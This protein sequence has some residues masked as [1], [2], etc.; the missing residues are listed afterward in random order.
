MLRECTLIYYL[1]GGGGDGGRG[2]FVVKE[3]RDKLLLSVGAKNSNG[4]SCII[5]EK[6]SSSHDTGEGRVTDK[7]CK[8][9][10]QL[11]LHLNNFFFP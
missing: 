1:K 10:G 11:T 9:T 3:Q 8:R 7:M 2:M 4:T 5:L 6:N